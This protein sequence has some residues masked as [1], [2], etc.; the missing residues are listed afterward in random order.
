[1]KVLKHYLKQMKSTYKN[2][3]MSC[4]IYKRLIHSYKESQKINHELLFED[5]N[6]G[7]I[8]LR[9]TTFISPKIV[10][11]IQNHMIYKY[12]IYFNYK[13]VDFKINI[14]TENSCDVNK[15]IMYIKWIICL[16]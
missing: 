3:N 16:V 13:N 2:D 4:K 11:Y 1:M 12:T 6:T 15:Y 5:M 8:S 14:C 10:K 9:T 7:S